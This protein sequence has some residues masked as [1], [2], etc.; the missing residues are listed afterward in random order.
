MA[1]VESWATGVLG[2][3]YDEVLRSNK[4][5]LQYHEIMNSNEL[6]S[7]LMTPFLESGVH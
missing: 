5:I 7:A 6:D 4:I 3:G 1:R 2:T